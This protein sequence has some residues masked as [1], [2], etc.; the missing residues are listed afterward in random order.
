MPDTYSQPREVHTNKP[1]A[2]PVE[3]IVES[4]RR[5]DWEDELGLIFNLRAITRSH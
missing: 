5:N 1:K 4:M 2:M 3:I